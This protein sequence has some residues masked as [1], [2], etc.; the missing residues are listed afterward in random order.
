MN[1]GGEG[2]GDFPD[3]LITSRGDFES[4]WNLLVGLLGEV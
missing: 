4:P 1:L 2:G 3:F